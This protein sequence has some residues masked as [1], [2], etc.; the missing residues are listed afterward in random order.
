MPNGLGMY[1]QLNEVI[2]VYGVSG[3]H[4]FVQRPDR[5]RNHCGN[6]PLKSL[7]TEYKIAPPES[8]FII[9]S[10]NVITRGELY[11]IDLNTIN[12]P[13]KQTHQ[14]RVRRKHFAVVFGGIARMVI[15]GKKARLV[16]R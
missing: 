4:F 2:Q 14:T 10:S 12:R 13:R 15:G 7:E 16:H 9:G 3:N 11:M 5:I 6:G 8:I 1:Y